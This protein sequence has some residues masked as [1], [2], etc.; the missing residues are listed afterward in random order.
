MSSV[1]ESFL[2]TRFIPVKIIVKIQVVFCPENT[3]LDTQG[4]RT[5]ECWKA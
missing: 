2:K 3:P 5:A 1:S 4:K